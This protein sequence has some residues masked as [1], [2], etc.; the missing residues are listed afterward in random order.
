MMNYRPSPTTLKWKGI[1][2]VAKTLYRTG[3]AKTG[4]MESLALD[5]GMTALSRAVMRGDIEILKILLFIGRVN[6]RTKPT[7]WKWKSINV[8]AKTLYRMG[9]SKAGL[10]KFLAFEAGTTALNFAVVRGDVEIVKILLEHGAD[11]YVKNDLGMNAFD[12]CN[13]AGPFPS[14]YRALQKHVKKE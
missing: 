2:F 3:V 7:T 4:L 1:S 5:C 14:V 10:L 6:S 9:I 8:V 13:N 11:P 12:M